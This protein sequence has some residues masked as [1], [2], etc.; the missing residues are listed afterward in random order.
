MRATKFIFIL[1]IPLACFLCCKKDKT[2]SNTDNQSGSDCVVKTVCVELDGYISTA[3][4]LYDSD[5]R[6]VGS[7]GTD[8]AHSTVE[9]TSN[10]VICKSFDATSFLMRHTIYTLSNNGIAAS[11]IDKNYSIAKSID[12]LIYLK[13]FEYNSDGYL[14]MENITKISPYHDTTIIT[15]SHS[16]SGGNEVTQTVVSQ[17]TT[18]ITNFEYYTD[19]PLKAIDDKCMFP[20]LGKANKNPVKKSSCSMYGITETIE[21]TYQFNSNDYITKSTSVQSFVGYPGETNTTIISYTY[22]CK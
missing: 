13:T 12:S 17:G 2:N 16:Y 22:T 21:Y 4:E 1:I 10:T 8:G 7:T 6:I 9:Y 15:Q 19:K 3:T 11:C 5:S 14:T 18:E 20:F